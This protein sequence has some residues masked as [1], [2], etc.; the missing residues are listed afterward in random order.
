MFWDPS[1]QFIMQAPEKGQTYMI[2]WQSLSPATGGFLP[3]SNIIML[4]VSRGG[5]IGDHACLA[6]TNQPPNL[7]PRTV[8]V[9]GLSCPTLHFCAPNPTTPTPTPTPT[10]PIPP[11]HKP[12]TQITDVLSAHFESL[13]DEAVLERVVSRL[14]QMYP[15]ANTTSKLV[16]YVIPRWY[17]NPLSHGSYTNWPVRFQP[18]GWSALVI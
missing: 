7:A 4:T 17:N 18:L 10:S 8:T 12:P 16:G 3:G 6:A 1:T 14:Q 9:S 15:A 2:L 5:L 13:S 11:L